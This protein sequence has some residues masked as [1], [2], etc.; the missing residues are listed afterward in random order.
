[1]LLVPGFMTML[2]ADLL[3]VA[4]CHGAAPSSYMLNLALRAVV[5]SGLCS[6]HAPVGPAGV[7]W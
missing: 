3:S 5:S 1:M 4:R 7:V 6:F 2:L